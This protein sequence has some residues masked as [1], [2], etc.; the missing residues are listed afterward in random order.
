MP[1]VGGRPPTG[2]SGALNRTR[3]L[4]PCAQVQP[5]QRRY[6]GTAIA[7]P[8]DSR[9]RE[10][11]V[12][13]PGGS[14]RELPL[15]PAVCLALRACRSDVV[16]LAARHSGV[17]YRVPRTSLIACHAPR[18]WRGRK[19]AGRLAGARVC[20]TCSTKW[21]WCHGAAAGAGGHLVRVDEKKPGRA[22][23]A[24]L[25]AA[26]RPKRRAPRLNQRCRHCAQWFAFEGR[27][28]FR[29]CPVCRAN[30]LRWCSGS[31][32]GRAHAV[33]SGEIGTM[34]MCRPCW[35]LYAQQRRLRATSPT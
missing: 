6:A 35:R 12:A 26:R 23:R 10:S 7:T 30:G 24:C 27:G 9:A 15:G 32:P 16:R 25:R 28:R 20:L 33:H 21:A 3:Q 8:P 18:R 14:W 4:R 22:C 1:A 13:G 5:F 11:L 2:L 34:T 31:A 29:L 17:R 19:Q